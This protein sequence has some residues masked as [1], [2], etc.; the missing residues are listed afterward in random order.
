MPHTIFN[1]IAFTLLIATLVF[2]T[3]VFGAVHQSIIAFTYVLIGL[4]FVLLAIDWYKRGE[5][6]VSLN[7]I[8]LPLL[9]AAVYGL[10]QLIPFGSYAELGGVADIPRTISLDLFATLVSA[11]HFLA[12]LLV[13][14]MTLALFDS[15]TRIRKLAI[16]IC[17]FGFLY[18][19]FAILQSVLSPDAIYGFYERFGAAP[20]GSFVSRNNFAAWIELAVAVP[21]GLILSGAVEKD[22]RL[23][24]LTSAGLMGIALV[25]SGSRG[26]LVAF[27]A[28]VFFLLVLTIRSETAKG[29]ALKFALAGGLLVAVVAGSIFVGGESSLT[30]LTED[31]AAAGSNVSRL[32]IWSVTLKVIGDGLPL[33]VG[34]GA[35]GVAYTRFDQN[36][37]F[38]R[39][40]QAHN[41]YLQVVSDAGIVGALLGLAFLYF[42]FR[43][44]FRSVRTSNPYRRGIATGAF[45]GLFG[46]LVHSLFD[47]PLHTTAI[48]LLFLTMIAVLVACGSKY[49]D[50]VTGKHEGQR[51]RHRR[52]V[53]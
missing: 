17:V 37:G 53:V 38:E 41:D 44:G 24:Y 15:A 2:T 18:S 9:G 28:E 48:S 46:V 11:L 51:D 49:D 50:D 45:A 22:K 34:L 32:H 33:G 8:Q 47:F 14:S 26:G 4:M 31:Q 20:F 13:F 23:L 5:I 30:R 52:K 43:A 27:I 16:T 7:A 40:E 10:I 39:V 36:S 1:K 3:L 29:K 42:L 6:R 19:F 35:F 21:L 12:L 25:V